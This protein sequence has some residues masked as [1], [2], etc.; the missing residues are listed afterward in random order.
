MKNIKRIAGSLLLL[1]LLALT[2]CRPVQYKAVIITGQNNHNWPVSHQAIKLILE[3]SG[4]FQVDLA[5][6][7]EKGGDFSGF[8]VDFKKYDVVVLDYNGDSWN[9][10]MNEAFLDYAR[11]GGGILVYHAADNAFRNWKEFNEIIALGGWEN[12][13]ETDGPYVYWKDGALVRDN[14]PGVG[15]SHGAQ[16]AYQM[17]SRSGDH[18][19]IKG[20]PAQ[21]KH[22]QD[23]LY[24][25][26]RGPGDIKDL[27]YTAY[28]DPEKR[29]SGREEPLV[30]TVNWQKARIFHIMI[31]HAGE[32]LKD[33]P[34]MQCTGF[35]TL[36]LRGAE[37]CASGK[38]TQEVPQDFPTKESTSMRLDYKA[39]EK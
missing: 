37:W 32:T 19:I 2:S 10:D 34:A 39:P 25:H 18:P 4:M 20:L 31:G 33:N 35:Q 38:V 12:R 13:N 8:N 24:D 11:K 1:C 9:Q 6:S 30:F 26:M 36:M 27:L 15:G 22:A 28:A 29:G 17:N 14:T 5:V 7:P 3:N 16:H 23:E 21:W